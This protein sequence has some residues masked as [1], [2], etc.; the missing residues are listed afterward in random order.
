[1]DKSKDGT[2]VTTEDSG[3]ATDGTNTPP[4]PAKG[5]SEGRWQ[6]WL[7]I[8]A[9]CV[10]SDTPPPSGFI[11]SRGTDYYTRVYLKDSSSS[12]IS[13]IGSINAFIVI[14]SGILTGPLYDRGYF[15]HLVY[16]GSFL[17]AVSLFLLSL[18][19]EGSFYQILLAQGIGAGLGGG[20]LY[21]PSMS[22][23]SARFGPS[24]GRARATALTIV[25]AGSS[26]GAVVHPVMLNR[27]LD[28]WGFEAAARANAALITGIVLLGC[29][30]VRD[31]THEKRGNPSSDE[32]LWRK[33]AKFMR[34]GPY[35]WTTAGAPSLIIEA[36]RMTVFII[37][38]Y[39]PLFYLQLDALLHGRS[40]SFS[41]NVRHKHHRHRDPLWLFG[42]SYISLIAPQI[43]ELT[44]NPAEI[45]ARLGIALFFCGLG[46]LVGTPSTG[47][48]HTRLHLVAARGLER[49]RR[50]CRHGVLCERYNLIQSLPKKTASSRSG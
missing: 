15:Y 10:V 38:Y 1:M 35:V 31:K 47:A 23:V 49:V 44:D 45:G 40:A 42:G 6:T 46:T 22:A 30:V 34:D 29:L 9:G 26:V 19:H 50:A 41:F 33:A 20:L 7:N 28:K 18:A 21:V 39:Y 14:S 36:R 32:S 3:N 17:T 37:A 4:A 11:R 25:A 27:T 5:S 48:P 12:V 8:L 2:T 13:W 43:V 16:A 24:A